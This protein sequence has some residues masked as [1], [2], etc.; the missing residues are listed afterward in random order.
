[1]SLKSSKDVLEHFRTLPVIIQLDALDI[2]KMY[3]VE[4]EYGTLFLS[5]ITIPE[6]FKFL[7]EGSHLVGGNQKR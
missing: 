7:C 4:H 2:S 5:F 6:L 3:V 1:M